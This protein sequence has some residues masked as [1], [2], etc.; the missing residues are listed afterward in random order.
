MK[1]L[2]AVALCALAICPAQASL[3]DATKVATFGSWTILRSVDKMTDKVT[4]TG[5][6]QQDYAK[7][8]SDEGLYVSVKGGISSVTLRFDDLPPRP[9]RLAS[10]IE[11]DVRAVML[12]GAEYDLAISSARLRG[13]IL[14]LIS[15]VQDFELDLTGIKDAVANIKAGCPIQTSVAESPTAPIPPQQAA[16]PES[17]A[18][19]P[20]LL[21]RMKA[22]KITSAQIQKICASTGS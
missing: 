20:D 1:N 18:C 13:Q 12:E 11:K 10:K 15:G 3:K 5:I 21:N 14:T 22:A 19:S 8:L 6:Y 2:F 4:C 9:M 7:Q 17:T 16:K